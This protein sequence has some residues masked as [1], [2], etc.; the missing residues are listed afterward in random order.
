MENQLKLLK[1]DI[2]LQEYFVKTGEL[3]Q[4]DIDSYKSTLSDSQSGSKMISI[5]KDKTPAA[6]PEPTMDEPTSG[7][8]FGGGTPY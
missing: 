7:G 6:S 4:A 5:F 2:R 8:S 1:Y 3:T